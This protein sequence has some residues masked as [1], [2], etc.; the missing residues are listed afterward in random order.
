[1]MS[2]N[3][4]LGTS[5]TIQLTTKKPGPSVHTLK[6]ILVVHVHIEINALSIFKRNVLRS[7]LQTLHIIGRYKQ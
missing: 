5:P 7:G 2:P 1:M 4:R 6:R 3:A